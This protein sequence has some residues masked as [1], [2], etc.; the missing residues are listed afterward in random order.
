MLCSGVCV[1][2]VY[3]TACGIWTEPVPSAL[4][5]ESQPPDHQRNPFFLNSSFTEVEMTY[6]KLHII[7]AYNLISFDIY[8]YP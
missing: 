5:A 4:E 3:Y 8:S 6:N 2:W 1:F 7:K